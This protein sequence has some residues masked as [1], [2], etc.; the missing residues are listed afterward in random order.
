M[1]KKPLNK[2]KAMT[3][4]IP[5]RILMSLA[6]S[7][8]LMPGLA[9][10]DIHSDLNLTFSREGR[11]D[12]SGYLVGDITNSS[13]RHYGCV[14]LRFSLT[15]QS[16]R[17]P[18]VISFK[19]RGIG[20]RT[21]VPFRYALPYPTGFTL[22]SMQLCPATRATPP[23][24]RH[25]AAQPRPTTP[26]PPSVRRAPASP[27][28]PSGGLCSIYGR[29]TGVPVRARTQ[30]NGPIETFYLKQVGV[31]VNNGRMPASVSNLDSQGAYRLENLPVGQSLRLEPLG[32]GWRYDQ[33]G[34]T[35][36]CSRSGQ[37][38]RV[39]IHIDGITID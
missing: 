21:R 33:R 20:P 7:A 18:T 8:L 37:S 1:K 30:L 11:N 32:V 39:D 13:T 31:Y 10:A 38:L 17:P 6:A 22:K 12:E 28:A 25:G 23:P 35:V 27:P 19:V 2:P 16:G 34:K 24:P 9:C 29:A 26:P 4:S 14:E 5:F 36:R 3:M 15:R